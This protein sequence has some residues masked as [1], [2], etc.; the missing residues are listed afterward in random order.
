M[1][2]CRLMKIIHAMCP[3]KSF[4]AE[5]TIF[6]L[7]TFLTLVYHNLLQYSWCTTAQKLK[8]KFPSCAVFFTQSRIIPLE[9]KVCNG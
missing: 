9:R 4:Q 7:R 6:F 5:K 1:K 3:K 2:S 8:E